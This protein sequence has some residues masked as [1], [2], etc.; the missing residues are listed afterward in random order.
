MLYRLYQQRQKTIYIKL[1]DYR[2]YKIFAK[3]AIFESETYNLS[4]FCF[5]FNLGAFSRVFLSV[6]VFDNRRIYFLTL[7]KACQTS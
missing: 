4:C 5:A 2:L 6:A 3:T 1:H 7:I